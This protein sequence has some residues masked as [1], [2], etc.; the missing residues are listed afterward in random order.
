M[1]VKRFV[2]DNNR[3]KEL[4]W[5]AELEDML[6]EN[7]DETPVVYSARFRRNILKYQ[8]IAAG[9]MHGY[10]GIIRD[11][12]KSAAVFVAAVLSSF[13]FSGTAYAAYRGIIE[14]HIVDYGDHSEIRYEISDY[15]ELPAYLEDKYM[16]GYVP[17]GYELEKSDE[18]NTMKQDVYVDSNGNELLFLQRIIG[19]DE[20]SRLNTEYS[21][22]EEISVNGIKATYIYNTKLEFNMIV[23]CDDSYLF[24]ITSFAISKDELIE[25]AENIII[26]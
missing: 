26:K 18:Y 24:E 21:V 12:Y 13:I 23:W 10:S 6:A 20:K 25:I 3:L 7:I 9:N 11:F 16:L 22:V 17:D 19:P 14:Y 8:K 15:S 2:K 1:K 5:L 4:L